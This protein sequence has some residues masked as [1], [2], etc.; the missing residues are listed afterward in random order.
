MIEVWK[1][2]HHL[3][4]LHSADQHT[5]FLSGEKLPHHN[6]KREHMNLKLERVGKQILV[7]ETSIYVEWDRPSENYRTFSDTK[8]LPPFRSSGA[9]K[10]SVPHTPPETKEWHF[11]FE[12]PRDQQPAE[13]E[14]RKSVPGFMWE[15]SSREV[16]PNNHLKQ[17]RWSLGGEGYGL[18]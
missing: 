17:N 10:G 11:T 8:L 14:R 12:R 18:D 7:I 4:W 6:A 9:I 16:L 15:C 2:M 3:W 1:I 13:K 5:R